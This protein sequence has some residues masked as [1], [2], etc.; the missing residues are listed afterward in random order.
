MTKVP[1]VPKAPRH[2][3]KATRRWWESVM[4]GFELEDHHARLLT[5]AA[6]SWD[7]CVEARERLAVDGAYVKDRFGCLKAHPAVV[8]ERD[9]RIAFCRCLR[10]LDLDIELP[11]E[12]KRPPALPRYERR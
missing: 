5:L 1:K 8:V 3:R 4:S 12:Q 7:R 10:E 9:S 11:G 2:L 6:E